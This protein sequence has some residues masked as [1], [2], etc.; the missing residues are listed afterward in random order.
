M[1][2]EG[3]SECSLRINCAGIFVSFSSRWSPSYWSSYSTSESSTT[4]A[5]PRSKG[6]LQRQPFYNASLKIIPWSLL[7]IFGKDLQYQTASFDF[8]SDLFYIL[9]FVRFGSKR[10]WRR[11]LNLFLILLCIVVTF[12]CCHTPRSPSLRWSRR[13]WTICSWTATKM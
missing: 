11:E 12:I 8:I 2:D 3:T 7:S 13:V 1:S 6:G 10:R 9:I 5:R 4:L